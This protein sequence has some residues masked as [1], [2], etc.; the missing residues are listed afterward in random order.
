MLVTV[1]GL[2]EDDEEEVEVFMSLELG[3]AVAARIVGLSSAG[4]TPTPK[5]VVELG[6]AEPPAPLATLELGSADVAPRPPPVELVV[7]D[8]EAIF[9]LLVVVAEDYK[10]IDVHYYIFMFNRGGH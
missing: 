7:F 1:F 5:L 10:N 3:T 6:T 4:T 2:E 9:L 8:S